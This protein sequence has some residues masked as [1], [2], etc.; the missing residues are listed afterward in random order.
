MLAP[1]RIDKIVIDFGLGPTEHA[2]NSVRLAVDLA[3]ERSLARSLIPHNIY[4]D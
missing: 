2:Q 4:I 3:R 1:K